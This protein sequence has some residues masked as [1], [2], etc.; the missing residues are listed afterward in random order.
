MVQHSLLITKFSFMRSMCNLWPLE[1][2]GTTTRPV[3]HEVHASTWQITQKITLSCSSFWWTTYLFVKW[4][5]NGET[6][7]SSGFSSCI[8]AEEESRQIG[9][10]WLC[11]KSFLK[12]QPHCWRELFLEESFFVS[13]LLILF[14]RGCLFLRHL[15]V[16]RST[17][18]TT[19]KPRNGADFT[20]YRR[21]CID[22]VSI[23]ALLWKS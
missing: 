18:L 5:C 6:G 11:K 3:H 2:F 9:C 14:S 4:G 15:C 23:A 8:L 17:N 12:E 1:T 13:F 10:L 20:M 21:F 22:F 19:G 16:L 7:I